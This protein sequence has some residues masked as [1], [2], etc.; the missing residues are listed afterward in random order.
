MKISSNGLEFQPRSSIQLLSTKTL[1]TFTRCAA[2]CDQLVSCRTFDYDSTSKQCRLFEGDSST[3]SIISSSSSTSFVGSI[4]IAADLYSPIHNLSCQ[5]CEQNRYEVCSMNT[6]TCQCPEHAYWNGYICALQLFTNDTCENAIE[7][8][9]DLNLT[10]TFDCSSQ[11]SRCA[12]LASTSKYG[13][14]VFLDKKMYLIFDFE[15]F[16]FFTDANVSSTMLIGATV[17]GQ[18]DDGLN[19]NYTAILEPWDVLV[20]GGSK[21]LY[22]ADSVHRLLAFAP[23]TRTSQSLRSFPS[24]PT[25]LYFDNRTN[26]IYVSVIMAHRIYI[27]PS[28]QTIPS[29][30]ITYS[31]CSM[32]WLYQPSGVVVDSLGNVYIASYQ[33]N[34]VTKWAPNATSSTLIAGSST[35]AW[36]STSLLLN[37]PH[38]LALDEINSF[39]YVVDRFNNRV[40]RF[41]LNGSGIGV[42]V[43]GGNGF[44]SAANRFN[45]PTDMFLSKID[46]SIYVADCYNNRVQKWRRNATFGTTVAGDPSGVAGNSS[47]LL[48]LIFGLAIDD[49][50]KYLYVGDCNNNRIQRFSLP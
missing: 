1:S 39:I 4:R 36:G 27:W 44:G 38:G 20:V 33:C 41:P 13:S 43:A 3:G 42:T 12:P 37:T 6:S 18:C 9:S 40:Q 32:N 22:V 5:F 35:G 45:G 30:G 29:S 17:A 11:S 28:N 23:G 10:C 7:C 16:C 14:V 26:S 47:Y 50:E 34:W 46:G 31:N 21:T 15:T 19:T 48:N 25:I 2:A 8:R 24:W 49:E